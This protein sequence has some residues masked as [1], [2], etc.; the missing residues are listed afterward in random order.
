MEFGYLVYLIFRRMAGVRL[1]F[2]ARLAGV[3]IGLQ[4]LLKMQSRKVDVVEI[5]RALAEAKAA[6]VLVSPAELEQASRRGCD[7][8][9]IVPTLIEARRRGMEITIQEF[10]ETAERR[11]ADDAPVAHPA[12]GS[13]N[14]ARTAAVRATARGGGHSFVTRTQ[15][16][17]TL[18]LS[19]LIWATVA[20]GIPG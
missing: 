1:W 13:Q 16:T 8:R 19:F 14:V 7:L 15:S 18:I 12:I 20:S 2:F 17:S 6:G 9:H 3:S 5:V 4:E 10:V 11:N